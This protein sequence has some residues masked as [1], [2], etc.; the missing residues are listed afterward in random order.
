VD[1]VRETGSTNADLIAAARRGAPDG[2]VLVADHQ[3]AGRGRQG[4][5]WTAPPGAGLLCSV[6]FR[7]GP[8]PVLAG[9]TWAVALAAQQACH[10][11]AG[12][13]PE[14]KWPNDLI[15]GPR[16]LAGVLA[17]TVVEAGAVTAVVVGI[18]LNLEWISP[19]PDVA[20]RAITLSEAA[21]RPM[22]RDVVLA[23]FLGALGPLSAAWRDDPV[24]LRARYR[25][26]LA[27][28]DRAV[29]VELVDRVVTGRAIG[30][31]DDGALVVQD[32]AGARHVLRVGDVVHLRPG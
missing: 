29:R 1:H 2:T 31:G 4:R 21:G 11:V 13:T 5:T 16:K 14:L 15:I 3:T 18:G 24:G 9:A 7:P 6:L 17:E 28:L 26:A 23:A 10:D 22:A 12:V 19:P 30:I 25:G 32:D 27:T 8:T 20:E